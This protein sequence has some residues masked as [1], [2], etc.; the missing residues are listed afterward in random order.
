VGQVLNLSDGRVLQ[1]D[2]QL[3]LHEDTHVGAIWLFEDVTERVRDREALS[4]ARD[5]AVAT[6]DAKG[7]FL[8]TMSHEIRTP[9]HGIIA[10]IDLLRGTPLDRDQREGIDVIS[11]SAEALV[12]IINDILDYEKV[13]AGRIELNIGPTDV[14]E[15]VNGVTTLLSAQA[16]GKGLTINSTVDPLLPQ[17]V[18]GD[19]SRLRQVL[20]NLAN[21]AVKFT[22]VGSV[23]LEVRH[24]RDAVGVEVVSFE[25]RDTGQG[26]PRDRL[27]SIFDPFV[28]AKAGQDGTGLG[29][30]I[31]HRLVGLMGGTLNVSSTV[32][33]G[34]RF[35]FSIPMPAHSQTWETDSGAAPPDTSPAD[36]TAL[37]VDDSDASRALLSRQ[38]ARLGVPHRAVAS[39]A[40]AIDALSHRVRYTSVLLDLDMPEM[41]GFQV[42]QAIRASEDVRVARIPI[43]ALTTQA[44]QDL[45][46]R[47]RAAQ[48]DGLL[49]KPVDLSELR[50]QFERLHVNRRQ[51]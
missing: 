24:D 20:L 31:A 51:G 23:D 35:R 50:D 26:I 4:R 27:E 30:A 36:D 43:I 32:G 28:Q 14:R 17:R 6:S 42:A 9:M 10:Q 3:I 16:I 8:A 37:I 13:E 12:S 46:A 34:S 48:M 19:G 5:L 33:E 2:F 39:G 21:N 38:V 45:A 29:L 15:V 41:D 7:Q 25:V 11:Q 47:C 18:L 1:F 44:D 49:I 40:E 22:S